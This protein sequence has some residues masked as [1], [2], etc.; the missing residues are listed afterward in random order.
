METIY[1]L[2]TSPLCKGENIVLGDTYR[3][4]ILTPSLIRMEY[5]PEGVFEDRA[6][7]AI[8]NRDFEVQ[9]F[10][11]I[12]DGEKLEIITDALHILYDKSV[13]SRNGLVVRVKGNDSFIQG[14]WH[15]SDPIY[16]LLG[17]A[18]TL[19]FANGPVELEHGLLSKDGFSVYDDSNS[20]L[21]LENGWVEPRRENQIDLYFFGYGRNYL[22]CIKDFYRLTGETPLLPKYALGNWWSRFYPY[23]EEGYKALIMRFEEEKIPFTVSVIDMDWHLVHIPPKYG[24]GWTGYTW[25]RELF[26]DPAAFMAW[27]HNKGYHITLNVHPAD[28]V[29]A[30][31][32]IYQEMAKEL[33]IDYEKEEPISFD[34]TN[35]EYLKAYFKYLHHQNEKDG[36]DFWWIDWQQGEHSKLKGLD[37]LWMLNHYHY[38]DNK[39]NG[40]RALILSRYAGIGSH[41]YPIGFSGDSIVSW[42]SLDFQPYFTANASNVGYGWWSHDIGGHMQGARDDELS[43]RW[44]QFGVFS[45]IMRLHSTAN[46]FQ[47]KEPWKFNAISHGI[48]NRFL[49]L[50]HRLIPYLYTMNFRNHR[51]GEPLIQPMYY[52]HSQAEEAYQVKN[53]YYFGSELIVAPIT[54]P[55]DQELQCS[56]V[57]IWL[58]KG[59]YI[60]FFHGL[61]YQGDRWLEMHRDLETI[62]VLAK[63]GGIVPLLRDEHA[64]NDL[65]NPKD[66]EIRIFAGED[67]EFILYEDD[68]ESLAYLNGDYVRTKM[69]MDWNT[70]GIFRIE[71]AQGNL[72][73]L[74]VSRNYQLKFIGF[75]DKQ[76]IKV[77]SGGKPIDFHKSYDQRSNAIVITIE[78][79]MVNEELCVQFEQKPILAA[80]QTEE[81]LFSILDRAQISFELKEKIYQTVQRNKETYLLISNLTAMNLDENLY[82]A[83]CEIILAKDN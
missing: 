67:G 77:R 82:S 61:I 81:F 79:V 20:F 9:S 8:L 26:P 60:D 73:L 72:D 51:E 16:D 58:P 43:T 62:P 69:S 37:P 76:M 54:K 31:E 66:M 42:E 36:V 1:K 59:I 2:K 38:L 22:Q 33:G 56:K 13:F 75:V 78:N 35:M 28:G 39:K 55:M 57:K 23:S 27:L 46:R 19:D 24:S 6:T 29:R 32:E 14:V 41:R 45:P 25:N 65:A 53:Q 17:T 47:G 44:L 48:M 63:A 74:P 52:Q 11:V 21:L 15:Y 64:G 18:R 70:E 34:V 3:F 68:G 30:H 50:R 40:K 4:T 12:D 7:Q 71:A 49:R 5:D 10:Q 83:L 80:N